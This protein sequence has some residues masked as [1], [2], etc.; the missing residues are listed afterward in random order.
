MKKMHG[1]VVPVVTPLDEN[2]KVDV[3]ALTELCEFLVE[4][5]IHCLYPC[6]TTGE[7]MNLS[8]EERK[9]V[10]ETCLKVGKG[11]CDVFAH[12]GCM[13]LRD[14]VELA[15]HAEK[16]GCDG[17][18]VVTPGFFK[19]SDDALLE[20]YKRVSAS[21]SK[22]FPIY[23]Y[24]IPQCA[25]NDIS[26]A[27]AERIAEACP[28]VVGIKYSWPDMSKIQEF[29][30][31]KNGEFS[32]LIGPDNLFFL[33]MCA[34]GVGVVS[35]TAMIVPEHYVGIYDKYMAGDFEGARA[36]QYKTNVI[37]HIINDVNNI[38]H[39]KA[40]L[41]YRGVNCKRFMR[42]PGEDTTEA[43]EKKLIAALEAVN[44]TDATV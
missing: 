36:L 19:Q 8:V 10:T 32:V 18:G 12:V 42:S 25:V 38:S 39:Y 4:K 41:K 35:G 30:R 37:N 20:Y 16:I 15:Q 22:D 5:G 26:P 9:L 33:T 24:A 11:K 29:T 44:Y 17:I 13:N 23:L 43:E 2:D 7:M 6:G 28:N 14:T 1:I 3:K 40:L 34:G 21:V 27:L 31:V